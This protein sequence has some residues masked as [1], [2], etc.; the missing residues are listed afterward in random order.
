ME[1]RDGG[2]NEERV[3]GFGEEE[4]DEGVSGL[5]EEG[6]GEDIEKVG[7]VVEEYV[8]GKGAEP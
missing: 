6:T 1:K 5:V 2:V 4:S 3:S 7:A 8:E